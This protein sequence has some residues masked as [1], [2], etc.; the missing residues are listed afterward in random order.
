MLPDFILL[1]ITTIVFAVIVV[2]YIGWRF[3]GAAAISF[4]IISGGFPAIMD[5]ISAFAIHNYEYPGQSRLWVF[6]FILFG[7]TSMCGSCL[8]L[9]EGILARRELDLITQKNL[10]WQAP[11]LTGVVAVV[12]D[13]FIDPIA[14]AARYWIWFV[15]GTI[16]YDIPLLNFVG[17]FVLMFLS[18]LAWIIVIRR[19]QWGFV[20]KIIGSI[21]AIVPLIVSSA[22]LSIF[23]NHL[24]AV[25]GW[26]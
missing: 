6:T 14:V 7:W 11:L 20:K 26:E 4:F 21:A 23:L 10:L 1:L 16:Y 22:I 2:S 24:I 19:Q 17:W 13:L 12:M 5:Y 18:S 15:K 25:F 3:D 8:F 9:S